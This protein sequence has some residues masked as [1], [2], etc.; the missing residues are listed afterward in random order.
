[1]GNDEKSLDNEITQL[2]LSW[3]AGNDGAMDKLMPLIYEKLR[4]IASRCLAGDRMK[5]TL[6]TTALVNETYIRIFGQRHVDWQD[7]NHFFAVAAKIMKHFIIYQARNRRAKK[8]GGDYIFIVP[9]NMDD[10]VEAKDPGLEPLAEAL[11]VL[12]EIDRR[13][14]WIF[15]MYYFAGMKVEEIAEIVSRSPT[16]VMRD[17]RFARSWLRGY[18]K[19]K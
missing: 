15:E 19:R 8:R 6:S 1:M 16:T 7:R 14:V 2:L 13:A 3:K 4:A 9:E 12:E 10:L 11:E 5:Q 17:L 18:L